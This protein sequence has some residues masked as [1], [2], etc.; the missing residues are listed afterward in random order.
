MSY[1]ADS[2][3]HVSLRLPRRAYARL[4]AYCH[5]RTQLDGIHFSHAR[6]IDELV[7]EHVP[8]YT[9]EHPEETSS[10]HAQPAPPARRGRP[11][12][13]PAKPARKPA[14]SARAA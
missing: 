5:K 2:V 7:M 8:D 1:S 14:K 3:R 13:K 10:L 4:V 11:A 6:A 9:E 12:R